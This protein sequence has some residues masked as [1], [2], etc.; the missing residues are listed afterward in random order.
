ML[1]RYIKDL[2]Y[3]NERVVIPNLGTIHTESISARIDEER[4]LF[5]PPSKIPTFDAA[6]IENDG[7]LSSYIAS[8]DKISLESAENYIHFQVEEWKEKLLINDIILEDIGVFSMDQSGKIQFI[9]DNSFNYHIESYGMSELGVPQVSKSDAE[10]SKQVNEKLKKQSSQKK[11]Q[12]KVKKKEQSNTILYTLLFIV[13]AVIGWFFVDQIIKNNQIVKDMDENLRQQEIIYK[14]T[15][16]GSIIEIKEMLPHLTF[17]YIYNS[18]LD[19]I[20]P[21]EK[22]IDTTGFKSKLPNEKSLKTPAQPQ[23]NIVPVETPKEVVNKQE[24][25][26]NNRIEENARKFWVIEG[27]YKNSSNAINRVAELRKSGFPG[28]VMVPK[29][30]EINYVSYGLFPTF[31]QANAEKERIKNINPQVWILG[32]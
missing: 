7:L 22:K 14:N 31:E 3:R 5:Y 25:G 23:Q 10:N 4:N 26:N 8:V 27:A 6:T 1:A 20:I 29:K 12:Q 28:A 21:V 18:A 15:L 16:N 11:T 24:T 17:R 9:P 13:F 30:D 19:S 32:N 2:L